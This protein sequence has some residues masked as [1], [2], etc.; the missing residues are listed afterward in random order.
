MAKA[1]REQRGEAAPREDGRPTPRA[2]ANLVALGA[3]SA[4]WSLFL[5]AELVVVRSGGTAF[6]GLGGRFD[7]NAVWSSAFASGV[8][9]LTGVPL[10]GWGL[11]WSAAAFA[12]PL[13]LLLRLSEARPRGGLVS[14]VR[15]TAL[16]GILAVLGGTPASAAP[17]SP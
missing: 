7:C 1:R 4:L 3:L 12:L 9:R 13:A 15:L 2:C 10:A 16:A 8:H 17:K 5:W 6:C 14:A 11:V